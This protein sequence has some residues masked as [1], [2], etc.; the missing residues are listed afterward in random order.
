MLF[1]HVCCKMQDMKDYEREQTVEEVSPHCDQVSLALKGAK[2]ATAEKCH[3]HGDRTYQ[4]LKG[5]IGQVMPMF[6]VLLWVEDELWFSH[7]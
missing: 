3:I 1:G 4:A 2:R 7:F 5:Q 6:F